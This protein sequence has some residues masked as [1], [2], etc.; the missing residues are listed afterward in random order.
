MATSE[1]QTLEINQQQHEVELQN[2]VSQISDKT[3]VII[4]VKGNEQNA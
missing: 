1:T 2:L 3:K 4:H